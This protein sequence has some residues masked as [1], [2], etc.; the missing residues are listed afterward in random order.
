MIDLLIKLLAPFFAKMGVSTAD[1]ISY[2]NSLK[3]YIYLLLILLVVLIA[4]LVGAHWLAK[5]RK[6]ANY[7]VVEE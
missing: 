4:V 1:V 5:K 2:A 6:K 7:V 3:G